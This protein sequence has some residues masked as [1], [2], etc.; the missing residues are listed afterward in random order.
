MGPVR[1]SGVPAAAAA[2]AAAAVL[3][4]GGVGEGH[5]AYAV[6][7][8]VRVFCASGCFSLCFVCVR[9]CVVVSA[10]RVKHGGT[11]CLRFQAHVALPVKVRAECFVGVCLL[12]DTW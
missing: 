8:F 2:A 9:V 4:A 12:C 11:G 7:V 5:L 10:C 1:C 3:L 6:C